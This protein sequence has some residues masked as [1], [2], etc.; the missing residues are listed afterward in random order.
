M[1]FQRLDTPIAEYAIADS[2]VGVP[3]KLYDESA[4]DK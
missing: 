4:P 1:N 3:T 2:L